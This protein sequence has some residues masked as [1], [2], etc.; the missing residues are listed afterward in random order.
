MNGLERIVSVAC[1]AFLAA[2]TALVGAA[3]T[4]PQ[5]PIRLLVP[6]APGGNTD[7]LARAV[8]VRLTEAWSTPVVVD[9]RGSASGIVASEIA[10][11]SAPD[12][13]TVFVGSTREMSVNPYLFRKLPYDPLKDFAAVTQGTISPILLASHPS[14]PVKN[15]R[16]L[17]DYAKANAK[18]FSY[19]SP[20]IGTPMHLSGELL[21]ML[22]GLHMVHIA[23]NGGGP[24]T[25][26]LLGGQEIKFG[27]LGMGP[28]IPHVKAGRVRPLAISI[29]HR[30]ALLP[31]VPTMIE[32]GYKDFDTS[33]WFAFFVPANSPKSIVARLNGE[34]VRI[35]KNR[36]M[37]D[38]L[39]NTG[40]EVAPGTPE[41][42][43][44]TVKEDAARYGKVI[45]AANIQPE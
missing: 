32:L 39:L 25:T 13:Y 5:K 7:I 26:A 10:A 15:V 9:N 27:F 16:E 23:Y 1:A 22:T 12:G 2:T 24:A 40:V 42:L 43:A 3:E 45:K 38:F 34:L 30:S 28:A 14:L 19:G 31:E 6:Y 21:N 20:G 8:G 17:L 33:I 36:E 35:L 41:E 4:Y 44:R 29:A 37:N 18:S 11:K